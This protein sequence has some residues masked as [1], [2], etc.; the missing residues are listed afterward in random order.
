MPGFIVKRLACFIAISAGTGGISIIVN[1]FA[2]SWGNGKVG[3]DLGR[4]LV[5]F[6]VR[7]EGVPFFGVSE[8]DNPLDSLLPL[9]EASIVSQGETVGNGYSKF[10]M[11]WDAESALGPDQ[12]VGC[13]ES[14]FPESIDLFALLWS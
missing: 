10:D 8:F 1:S 4:F 6:L 13:P 7:G 3:T 14:N 12:G 11:F 2:C 5:N 9:V